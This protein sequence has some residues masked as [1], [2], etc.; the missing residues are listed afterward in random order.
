MQSLDDIYC[1]FPDLSESDPQQLVVSG[2]NGQ[3]AVFMVNKLWPIGFMIHIY[4]MNPEA[5]DLPWQDVSKIPPE[6]LDDLYP[7]LQEK[8]SPVKLVKTVVNERIAPL[9]KDTLFFNFV[10]DISKSHVRILFDSKLYCS[11]RLG[12]DALNVD[13]NKHTMS[14]SFLDVGTVIHEFCHLLGMNHEHQNPRGN[15]LK[16]NKE[17][18]Y[19]LFKQLNYNPETN[20]SWTNKEIDEQIMNPLSKDL[21]KGSQYDEASIMVYKIPKTVKCYEE[22]KFSGKREGSVTVMQLT[23]DGV[24]TRINLRLS[25]TDI[26]WIQKAYDKDRTLLDSSSIEVVPGKVFDE[27]RMTDQEKEYVNSAYFNEYYIYVVVA[28]IIILFVAACILI[29]RRRKGSLRR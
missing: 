5:N 21:T 20:S 1:P 4:F 13:R 14:F 23:E 22:G 25:P 9:V 2:L 16:W 7:I 19:C 10:T 8:V 27:A 6:Y 15:P 12:T 29:N 18:V 24:S 26:L 3:R 17:A 28:V 11:S